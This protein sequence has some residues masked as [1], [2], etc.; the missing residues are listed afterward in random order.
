VDD[1]SQLPEAE[2]LAGHIRAITEAADRATALLR[3]LAP[4]R[5]HLAALDAAVAALGFTPPSVEAAAAAPAASS[6]AADFDSGVVGAH[7]AP[8]T[9][10]AG[11]L[12]PVREEPA[13]PDLAPPHGPAGTPPAAG[14]PSE[15]PAAVGPTDVTS[16]GGEVNGPSAPPAAHVR[17]TITVTVTREDAPLDLV[18]VHSAL[19]QVQGVTSLALVSYTRG[20]AVLQVEGDR[21]I[22]E[23]RLTEGLRAA[24]PEG[25][26]AHHQGPDD[27]VVS[28]GTP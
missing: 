1:S 6:P 12:T 7:R 27:I 15:E 11:G 23:L 16:A 22:D 14:V 24:F 17:R 5:A 8:V 4:L 2:A 21:P 28:I 10:A 3:A 19:D 9:P 20:R 25:V 13:P 18:R 26:T